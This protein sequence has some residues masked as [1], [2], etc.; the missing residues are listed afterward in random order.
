MF[1]FHAR[2]TTDDEIGLDPRK[3]KEE[4]NAGKRTNGL[5]KVFTWVWFNKI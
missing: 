5:T 3:S 1:Y 4:M 2:T